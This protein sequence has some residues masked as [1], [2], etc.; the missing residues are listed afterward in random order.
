[1]WDQVALN[2]QRYDPNKINIYFVGTF[3]FGNPSQD[4]Q[5][6]NTIDPSETNFQN[7]ITIRPHIISSDRGYDLGGPRPMALG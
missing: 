7:V 4:R 3:H 5:N 2:T 1:M 6:G